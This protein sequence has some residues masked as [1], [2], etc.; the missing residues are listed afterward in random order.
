M[1]HAHELE[2]L[3]SSV[4]VYSPPDRTLISIGGDDAHAWLQGQLTNQCEDVKPGESVYGFILSL[5]GR[6]LADAW[7]YFHDDGV[8]LEVPESVV[9]VLME[10][11]D[12]YIIMEDVDLEHRPDL[13]VLLAQGPKSEEL[14]PAGWRSDRL[15]TG[16]IAW[17]VA[18]ADLDAELERASE[19]AGTL[20]G[21]RIGEQAWRHAHVVLGRPLFGVDFGEWTYPQETGLT[22]AA[23]SFNKGCYVGQ[24]TVV[25]LQNRGKAPKA[26]WR[27]EVGDSD[28]PEPKT[29]ITRGGVEVGEVT[30]S[31]LIDGAV[32]ALGFLKRGQEAELE[33]LEIGGRA[34]RPVGPVSWGPG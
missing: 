3:R 24:E 7:A 30:S 20:G 28:A 31:A 27:W 9:D 26:L 25:M 10:R 4:G 19:R 16:G 5:K 8:W 13:H 32:Q 11:L 1:A 18:Q 23:V 21:G 2:W 29:P 33:G 6:V 22:G 17:L 15:G 12:R 34:A 14:A